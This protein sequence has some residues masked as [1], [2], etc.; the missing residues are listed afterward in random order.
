MAHEL[1]ENQI[2]PQRITKGM[3]ERIEAISYDA[4]NLEVLID[5]AHEQISGIKAQL[6]QGITRFG[7]GD[8]KAVFAL[9]DITQREIERIKTAAEDFA[10]PSS[11][12]ADAAAGR[13]TG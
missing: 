2:D 9:L 13:Q 10:Q 6:K 7:D 12:R 5:L 3:R 1:Y 4:G 11:A 8:F